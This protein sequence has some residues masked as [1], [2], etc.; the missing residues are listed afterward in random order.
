[1]STY[2]A[3]DYTAERASGVLIAMD[4]GPV[5]SAWAQ[6]A[7][8]TLV[9]YAKQP[10][11]EVLA[12]LSGHRGG[13]D[14]LVIERI[15]SY[16]MA[17]GAEVFETVYWSGRFAQAFGG[18][19]ER[20][21]RMAVKMHLCHSSRAKDANIRQA[22]IDRYGGPACVRKGGKLYGVKADIW[23]ALAVGLTWLDTYSTGPSASPT[24]H[25]AVAPTAGR[26]EVL[27]A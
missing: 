15:A 13:S 10:N 6:L 4:P 7:G 17:V 9:E 27:H 20:L 26:Q 18:R 3:S 25:K 12:M 14:V 16:G 23:S 2:R 1:M 22:I 19:V 11:E 21:P 5:R 8:D 24:A